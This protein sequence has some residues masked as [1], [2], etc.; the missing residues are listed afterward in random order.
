MKCLK[1]AIVL[2]FALARCPAQSVSPPPALDIYGGVAGASVPGCVKTGLFQLA[3]FNAHAVLADPL[4]NAFYIRAVD[5][6][7]PRFIT[8]AV[9]QKRYGSNLAPWFTRNLGVMQRAGFSIGDYG[10]LGF[11][12]EKGATVKLPHTVLTNAASMALNHYTDLGY[13]QP[14]KDIISGVPAARWNGYRAKMLDPFDPMWPKAAAATVANQVK[15]FGNLATDPWITLIT[16][17]DCDYCWALKGT[18]PNYPNM[19]WMIAVSQF[20]YPGY[21]DPKLYAKYA[22]IDYLQKKYV[23]VAALCKAWGA[24]D[25]THANSC[26]YTSLGDAGG[27][28]AGT[29]VLDE[30]GRHTKWMGTDAYCQTASPGVQAD[31]SQ[32]L[33]LFAL[34]WESTVVRAVRAADPNHAIASP[35]AIGAAGNPPRP[36]VVRAFA[37]A[38]ADV[39]TMQ[40]NPNAPQLSAATIT[41]ATA[42]AGK[43]AALWYGVSANC[44]SFWKSTRC[45][46]GGDAPDFPTQAVRAQH[47]A[48]DQR[49]IFSIA[50]VAGIHLW[51]LTD[52]DGDHINWGLISNNDNA[53]DG[54]CAVRNGSKDQWGY[55]CGGESGNYGDFLDPASRTN[56]AILRLMLLKQETPQIFLHKSATE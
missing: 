7:D 43:P 4:C 22:W 25:P 16:T 34:Q 28:G 27:Y 42:L 8:P 29:G 55:Q 15:D 31:C 51:A 50:S 14:I 37:D 45:P 54:R 12:P 10:V 41:A 30:D 1:L 26:A 20:A 49:L 24:S 35:S 47:Y 48:S 38:G 46:A 40:F 18:A 52:D 36:E 19:A 56:A 13:K 2:L 6:A 23:T 11:M 39:L 3:T 17:E 44:D 5:N 33:Y 53:Y 9:M 32:F 21:D